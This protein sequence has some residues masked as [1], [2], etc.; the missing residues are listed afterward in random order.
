MAKK[1]ATLVD[2]IVDNIVL[3]D[4]EDYKDP[5]FDWV[6]LTDVNPQPGSGWS[7]DGNVFTQPAQEPPPEVT[8]KDSI[9]VPHVLV[10][11]SVDTPTRD[12][13]QA[14]GGW[15][16]FNTDNHKLQY[17]DGQVWVST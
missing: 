17:F 11:F 1:Y 7:Y 13:L 9:A 15:M 6:D 3:A 4:E 14:K 12:A 8:A 2:G 16:I 5:Q 10:A